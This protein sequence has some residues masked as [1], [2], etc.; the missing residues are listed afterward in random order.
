MI[1][2]CVDMGGYFQLNTIQMSATNKS[3]KMSLTR[4]SASGIPASYLDDETKF[5][6]QPNR[7]TCYRW[8]LKETSGLTG[9]KINVDTYGGYSH[10]GGGAFW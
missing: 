3:T 1:V 5:L 8:P 4:L 10:H 9:R 2:Q 7:T 6:H